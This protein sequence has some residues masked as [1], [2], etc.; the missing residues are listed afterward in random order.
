MRLELIPFLPFSVSDVKSPLSSLVFIVECIGCP[1]QTIGNPWVSWTLTLLFPVI[2]V[3]LEAWTQRTLRPS[4]LEL[5]MDSKSTACHMYVF[6]MILSCGSTPSISH[7]IRRQQFHRNRMVLFFFD[8][9]GHPWL[10]WFTLAKVSWFCVGPEVS[11]CQKLNRH[12]RTNCFKRTRI[13][14]LDFNNLG[15]HIHKISKN[16]WRG[17][18]YCKL[19]CRTTSSAFGDR[20]AALEFLIPRTTRASS[21]ECEVGYLLL[22][23]VNDSKQHQEAWFSRSFTKTSNQY[24]YMLIHMY[25][26]YRC[27]LLK[28]SDFRFLQSENWKKNLIHVTDI[29]FNFYRHLWIEQSTITSAPSKAWGWWSNCQPTKLS[30]NLR[31]ESKGED[32]NGNF[33][34]F[35]MTSALKYITYKSL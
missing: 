13:I 7:I 5:G 14:M 4:P 35:L 22:C 23:I 15:K 9:A 26:I 1:H 3:I 21:I 29:L 16:I 18:K 8:E 32:T 20:I 11:S 28:H 19:C 25:I 33:Q 24:L 34:S 27:N 31:V 12:R 10:P 17:Q 6:R 2:L 30:G